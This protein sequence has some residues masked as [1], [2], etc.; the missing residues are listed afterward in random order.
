VNQDSSTGNRQQAGEVSPGS[1]EGQPSAAVPGALE[2]RVLDVGQGDS[3]LVR[4]PRGWTLL[5]DGGNEEQ[6][7]SLV[8]RLRELGV[9]RID[10]LVATHPHAD[11]IGGLDDVL[12]AFPVRQVFA[13]RVVASSSAYERLLLAVQARGLKVTPA[14]AGVELPV[15]AEE[16]VGAEFLAPRA[17]SHENLNE[18]S[19][20]LRLTFGRAAVLLCGDA[21]LA[22]EGRILASGA[23]VRADV[24][25]LGHHGS[26]DASGK[27]FLQAVQPRWAAISVGAGN[28]YGHPHAET[29]ARLLAMGVSVLRT[30]LDGE[31]VFRSD[32][33]T[34][35]ADTS[36]ARDRASATVAAPRR[37]NPEATLGP[38]YVGNLR[39][40]RFHL[41]SCTGLPTEH[42][43]VYFAT[44]QQALDAGYTPCG[45]CQP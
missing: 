22:S 39:S 20:V 3:I 5:V 44:R 1:R 38:G 32:G 14:A 8:A 41:P 16:R 15:P 25:K 9:T 28:P 19:A 23:G 31:L 21:G 30:D 4:A 27:A 45:T 33:V 17:D 34:V 18:A 10:C 12:S 7:P 6:G 36:P 29:L 24:I 42:N 11:H 35:A 2:V 40:K 37:P 13:P 43:R 26:T